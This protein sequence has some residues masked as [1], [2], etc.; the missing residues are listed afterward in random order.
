MTTKTAA[1]FF[2]ATVTSFIM[3]Y[4]LKDYLL[5]QETV[6]VEK[7]STNEYLVKPKIS[8]KMA[9]QA[10]AT[11]LEKSIYEQTSEPKDMIFTRTLDSFGIAKRDDLILCSVTI[12]ISKSYDLKNNQLNTVEEKWFRLNKEFKVIES[13]EEEIRTLLGK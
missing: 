5:S 8:N 13:T 10:C 9:S 11:Y 1:Y 2:L 12:E 7:H 4:E 6:Q 3:G